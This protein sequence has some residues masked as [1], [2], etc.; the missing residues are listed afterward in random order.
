MT[1]KK[2]NGKTD[3]KD[4]T[5]TKKT[6]DGGEAAFTPDEDKELL[7]LKAASTSWREIAEQ[8]N[9]SQ[10]ALKNR[11]K[12]IKPMDDG[13][14]ENKGGE[15]KKK[16]QDEKVDEGK[17]QQKGKGNGNGDGDA[18]GKKEGKNHAKPSSTRSQGGKDARFTMGRYLTLFCQRNDRLISTQMN[19]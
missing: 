15:N 11:F 9:K 16:Q 8:M 1:D 14:V 13:K 7:E 19:G 2:K 18:N 12:E 3:K 10:Q 17:K 4:K 5:S 6:E